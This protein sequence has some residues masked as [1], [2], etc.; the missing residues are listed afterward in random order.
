MLDEY[1]DEKHE[2]YNKTGNI[3]MLSGS[4]LQQ[5]RS[6]LCLDNL[7]KNNPTVLYI[8]VGTGQDTKELVQEGCTVDALDI[9]SVALNRVV[10]VARDVYL[11]SDIESLPEK[12]YDLAISHFVAQHM[13]DEDLKAQI[14]AVMP[15]L[16]NDG[17]FAL[18][19][20][21]VTEPGIQNI[22]YQQGGGCSRT[23]EELKSLVPSLNVKKVNE[24]VHN[25]RISFIGVHINGN[26]RVYSN[27]YKRRYPFN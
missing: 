3:Q 21:V 15:S 18:H 1:W 10:G 20:V 13:C 25:E 19:F 4:S 7:L 14:E 17:V 26:K 22:T 6:F 16:K 11:A 5:V 27:T 12:A 8:G 24:V 23:L 9:S 2:L